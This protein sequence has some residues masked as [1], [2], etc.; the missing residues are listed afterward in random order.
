MSN[1]AVSGLSDQQLRDG[2][3]D[4][5]ESLSEAEQQDDGWVEYE[6]M[7]S[8]YHVADGKTSG[9]M[10][11]IVKV[12]QPLT[13]SSAVASTFLTL[14]GRYICQPFLYVPTLSLSQRNP[15]DHW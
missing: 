15:R 10:V 6:L 1:N 9:N 11:A 14:L 13:L 4:I 8:V 3:L 7:A 2:N 12:L 5:K